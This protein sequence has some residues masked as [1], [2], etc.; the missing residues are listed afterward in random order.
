MSAAAILYVM[1][2]VDLERAGAV[3]AGA[4]WRWLLAAFGVVPALMALRGW[5]WQQI[6]PVADG[7]R[8][9]V[10]RVLVPLLVGNLAN[11]V[12]PARAGDPLRAYLLARRERMRFSGT[13]GSL[14]LERAMDLATL[15]VIGLPA[16]VAANAVGW[17]VSGL[18]LLAVGGMV[19]TALLVSPLVR[20]AVSAVAARPL[21]SRRRVASRGAG[22]VLSFSEGARGSGTRRVIGAIALSALTWVVVAIAIWLAARS[23]SISLDPAGAVVVAALTSL[24]TAIPSA[25]AAI[26]TY[27]LAAVVAGHALGVGNAEALALGLVAHA[28]TTLP[29]VAAGGAALGLTSLGLGDIANGRV[30]QQAEIRLRRELG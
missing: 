26:G 10:P 11:L 9:S 30:V 25:P 1:Q 3:L 20:H 29:F 22:V 13:L 24:G 17:M 16:A 19:L 18:A 27:E 2:S 28:V 23:L 7:A 4:D 5:R 8:P 12:L 14:A 21:I 6:L 15:A